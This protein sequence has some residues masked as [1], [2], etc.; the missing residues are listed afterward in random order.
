MEIKLPKSTKDLRI[1]HLKALMNPTYEGDLT[2]MQVNEFMAEFTGEHLNDILIIDAHDIIKMYH[3][4]KDLY[5]DI[6]INKPPQEV[7]LNGLVYELINPHK[8]GSGWHMDWGKG[9][10]NKDPVWMACLFYYPKGV[11]YG[12]TDENKNLLYPIKDRYNIF[13]RELPLQTFLEAS[14]FFLLKMEQSTRLSME[15]QKVME[16]T[17]KV[18]SLFHGKKQ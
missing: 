5:S 3:H 9:D 13:E 15:K 18:L 16:K 8:V 6:R 2:L 12:T 1:K 17:I 14:G 4:V 11:R 10:I 7:T